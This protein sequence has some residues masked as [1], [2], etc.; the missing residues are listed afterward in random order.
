MVLIL[1]LCFSCL[2]TLIYSN[3]FLHVC[4]QLCHVHLEPESLSVLYLSCAKLGLAVADSGC[5]QTWV[6][7]L[8][9]TFH[10]TFRG[11]SVHPTLHCCSLNRNSMKEPGLPPALRHSSSK[12]MNSQSIVLELFNASLNLCFEKKTSQFL[13]W[14]QRA[15]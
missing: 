12:A 10:P 11:Y 15:Q 4:H 13:L 5:T 6:F 3:T 7:L 14:S 9:L 1:P 8:I 2:V